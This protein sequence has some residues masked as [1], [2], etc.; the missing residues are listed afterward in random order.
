MGVP[1]VAG[2]SEATAIG[3]LLQQAIALGHLGTLDEAR[4]VVQGSFQPETFE[5]RDPAAWD[6]AYARFLALN[7]V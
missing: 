5:P 3:N 6:A 2:P 4:R 7:P 1:V